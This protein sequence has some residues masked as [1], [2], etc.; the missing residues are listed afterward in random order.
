MTF[1]HL[2]SV[3]APG[4]C[5]L[6][7]GCASGPRPE[8]ELA[9]SVASVKS[10]NELGA[11]AVPPAAL[12]FQLARD[13]LARANE[14]LAKNDNEAAKLELWRAKVDA[15]LAIALVRENRASADEQAA[16]DK[17][18]SLQRAATPPQE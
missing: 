14:H 9:D 11:A 12:E 1:K 4:L 10:A 16:E 6:G 18:H 5:L 15:E 7:I 8:T 13:E 2:S 3:V 17:L